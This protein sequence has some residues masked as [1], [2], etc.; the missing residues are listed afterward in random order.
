VCKGVW[1]PRGMV[2]DADPA[3]IGTQQHFRRRTLLEK[4]KDEKDANKKHETAPT[5]VEAAKTSPESS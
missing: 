4:L 1:L 5:S 2:D 3:E